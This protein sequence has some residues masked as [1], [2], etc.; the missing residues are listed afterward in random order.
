MQTFHDYNPA[1]PWP[2]EGESHIIENG[3]ITLDYAPLKGSVSIAGFLEIG[4]A[5][6]PE[7][8]F[9]IR[10]DDENQ[11][12]AADQIV[13]FSEAH[14]GQTVTVSYQGVSTLVR[15]KHFNEIKDFMEIGCPTLIARMMVAHES[16]MYNAMAEQCAHLTEA[17]GQLAES[18]KAFR[19]AYAFAEGT[20]VATNAEVDA[21]LDENP[22]LY[23]EDGIDGDDSS[24]SYEIATDE[25]VGEMLDS[26]F[27]PQGDGTDEKPVNNENQDNIAT[28]DEV[29]GMLDEIFG[30]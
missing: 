18:L 14:N 8:R 5:P 4:T 29:E 17:I 27:P 9:F 7:G 15:A 16:A 13:H 22:H 6:V 3:T 2:I 19:K 1:N 11:Y 10:Y 28:D 20:T 26:I 23:T 21:M 12:R 24:T 25:E 30:S